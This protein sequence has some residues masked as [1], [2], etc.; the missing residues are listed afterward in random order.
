MLMEKTRK[1]E[2][3]STH[4]RENRT[5]ALFDFDGTITHKD[6]LFAFIRFVKGRSRFFWGMVRL[7]PMLIANK[8]GLISNDKAKEKMLAY[9]F[10][11]MNYAEFKRLGEKF[12]TEKLPEILK[13]AALDKINWHRSKHHRVIVVSASVEEWIRPWTESMHIELL[14]TEMEVNDNR[15]TGKFSTPNCNGEEKVKRI[16]ELVELEDYSIIYAYGDTKGDEAM[17]GIATKPLY[18]HFD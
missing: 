16:K 3:A 17:L 4:T 5:L 2:E 11:G 15:L 7:L 8:I 18:Q 12:C 6:S 10:K 13:R 9:Y 14:C 1:M